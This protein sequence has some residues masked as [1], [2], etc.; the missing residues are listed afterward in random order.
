MAV[1]GKCPHHL[2]LPPGLQ[3]HSICCEV[4]IPYG[5]MCRTATVAVCK[6]EVNL[7]HQHFLQQ[8]RAPFI[9]PLLPLP[10]DPLRPPTQNKHNYES[11]FTCKSM[12]FLTAVEMQFAT[13]C[14]P[15]HWTGRMFSMVVEWNW[16]EWQHGHAV[17]CTVFK[18]HHTW[19]WMSNCCSHLVLS[20]CF[21]WPP[22]LADLSTSK[23]KRT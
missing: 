11:P 7:P 5:G 18:E 1:T 19:P 21:K 22:N 12:Q 16:T 10:I 20:G 17:V 15:C 6:H 2:L 13:I 3:W 8:S 14:C 23:R 9:Q 4:R